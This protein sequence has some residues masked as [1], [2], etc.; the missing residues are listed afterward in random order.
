MH[1]F[2][3]LNLYLNRM[4]GNGD[5][6]LLFSKHMNSESLSAYFKYLKIHLYKSAMHFCLLNYIHLP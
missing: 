1:V 5:G 4:C 2:I 3:L 6:S